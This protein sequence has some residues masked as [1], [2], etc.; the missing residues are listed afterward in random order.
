MFKAYEIRVSHLYQIKQHNLLVSIGVRFLYICSC[1]VIKFL[2]KRN[3]NI[4]AIGSNVEFSLH[5]KMNKALI[6]LSKSGI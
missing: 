5:R 6:P 4:L 2:R 3:Q 1:H